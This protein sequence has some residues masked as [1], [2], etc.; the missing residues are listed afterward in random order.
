[1]R[2]FDELYA[3]A[4]GHKG[5]AAALEALLP[6]PAGRDALLAEPDDRWLSTLSRCVFS[7]GFNWRV[8]ESKW[9]AFEEAFHGFDPG[10]CSM[11][12]DEALEV[13][14]K[15]GG[16]PHGAKA[17]SIR[18][19]AIL[20]RA[21]AEAHGS[22]AQAFADWPGSD[23]AGLL[24]MLK[25]RGNRL[26]GTTAQYFLRFMGVD[27]F[28]LGADG[29]AALVREGVVAKAVSSKRDLAA[30]QAAYNT[31]HAE[32]GRPYMQISRVLAASIG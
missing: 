25:T 4:A 1:M 16:I 20:F 9:P 31:W 32:S 2:S 28:V 21:L 11:M 23:F 5:G 13:A 6:T 8:V 26:G 30:T 17:W 7:A 14:M 22:A 15:A 27:G 18:E 29:I 24:T 19:N 3:M 10:R 12:E